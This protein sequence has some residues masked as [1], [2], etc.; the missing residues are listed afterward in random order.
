MVIVRLL[1]IF[2]LLLNTAATAQAFFYPL[3]KVTIKVTD[4]DGNP[5]PNASVTVR[6]D[7]PKGFGMGWGTSS[8]FVDGVTDK[9]GLYSLTKATP[10]R[11]FYMIRKEG[12]YLSGETYEFKDKTAGI[13]WWPW[14]PFMEIKLKKQINPTQ[15]YAKNTTAIKIPAVDTPVGYDLE[16]GDWVAPHGKGIISD[17]VFTFKVRFVKND[18]WD[19]SYTL[20]FSN[21]QDGIQEY[22]IPAGNQSEYFWPY[23]APED[24][25]KKEVN[26]SAFYHPGGWSG[27]NKSDYKEDRKYIFRVRSKIDEKGNII[28]AKYGKINGDI[29]LSF[30]GY[31]GFVYYFNPTGSR[32]LEFGGN[33]FKFSYKEWEYEVKGP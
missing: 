11:W 23:E 16:K 32:S 24:G 18:D 27:V 30:G 8:K 33:L 21:E 28:E 13:V 12:H 31:T 26:W 7:Y 15:M 25:Y 19:V 3:G 2:I 14:N 6:F 10:R 20:T 29:V 5:V 22:S 4:N 1:F 9:D 17:F